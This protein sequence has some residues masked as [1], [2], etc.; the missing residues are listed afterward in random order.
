M[1]RAHAPRF[2]LLDIYMPEANGW[3][4][5]KIFKRELPT[6]L[7]IVITSS[8]DSADTEEAVSVDAYFFKPFQQDA[9]LEKMAYLDQLRPAG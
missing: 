7:L 6:T 4:V 5:A 9:L 3:E 1:G 2:A 8:R